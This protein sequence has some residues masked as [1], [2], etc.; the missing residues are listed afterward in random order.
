[1]TGTIIDVITMLNEIGFFT[2]FLPFMLTSAIMYGLLRKSKIFGEAKE[3]V[4]I[5]A[6]I[7]VSTA[8]LVSAA[9]IIVGIDI[10]KHLAAFITYIIFVILALTVLFFIPFLLIPSL[11]EIKEIG[12]EIDRRLIVFTFF[13]VLLIFV[14]VG[15]MLFESLIK[16]P[17]KAFE[18]E[19]FF[20][21]LTLLIFLGVFSLL[22]YYTSKST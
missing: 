16:I 22:V 18:E 1:M 19:E 3:N 10:S 2:F 21:T 6:T 4:A 12:K 7:A 8:F 13:I 5:N 15:L 9:P 14:I 20:S 11:K 17:I